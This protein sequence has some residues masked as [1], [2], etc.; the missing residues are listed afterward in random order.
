MAEKFN[1]PHP[2]GLKE[3]ST[4]RGN[5]EKLRGSKFGGASVELRNHNKIA[6][7]IAFS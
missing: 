6:I 4:P 3:A 7:K 2:E 5:D 1:L